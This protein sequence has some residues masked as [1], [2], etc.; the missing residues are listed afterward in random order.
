M[1][2]GFIGIALLGLSQIALGET[3][4]ITGS[5]TVGAELMPRLVRNWMQAQ[6]FHNISQAE[7]DHETFRFTGAHT[8]GSD[9]SVLITAKGSSTGF[10]ALDESTTDLA[11]A[12]R[13]I[14]RSEL[15]RLGITD[16]V[17]TP[18]NE[19]IL[20]LDALAIVVH[21]SVTVDELSIQQLHD[22]FTGEVNNWRQVG[23]PDLNITRYAR[24]A[25]SGTYDAF[26]SMVLEGDILPADTQR[27]TANDVLHDAVYSQRGAIGFV[28]LAFTGN[29]KVLGVRD[30]IGAAGK[31]TLFSVATE[32]YVLARRLYLYTPLENVK[33]RIKSLLE[34]ALSETGQA[35]VDDVHYVSLDIRTNASQPGQAPERY[36]DLTEAAERLSVNIRFHRGKTILDAKA[37]QDLDRLADYVKAR[38]SETPLI[39]AG[40]ASSS[41]TSAYMSNVLSE[42][43][44]DLVAHELLKRGLRPAQVWGF[45][46][47]LP[48]INAGTELAEAKNRRVEIWI[49]HTN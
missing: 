38:G 26:E 19:V 30:G 28:P 29:L 35:I 12:S 34:Y 27:F 44:A 25:N 23:G 7:L 24:D 49:Q 13:P 46:A 20:A 14:R 5:N 36:L 40:F 45:G 39:L 48:I 6:G 1:R 17:K 42:N 47:E 37:R 3:L 43:R 15:T 11:M 2:Y 22:I 18:A 10:R 32:D 21:E 16:H 41:E 8:D 33:P 31:P 9:L 4:R